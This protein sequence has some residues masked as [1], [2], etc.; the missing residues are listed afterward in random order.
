MGVSKTTPALLWG[1]GRGLVVQ[2]P[3]TK[4]PEVFSTRPGSGKILLCV[5]YFVK[6]CAFW[7]L[8]I[9]TLE[10][11]IITPLLLMSHMF[12]CHSG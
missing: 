9:F 1:R 12:T 6:L 10:M 7:G 8:N 4:E 11:G 2:K 3:L 5:V